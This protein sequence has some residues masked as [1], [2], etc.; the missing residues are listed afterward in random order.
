MLVCSNVSPDAIDDDALA[1]AQL[2]ALAERA[3]ERGIRI[4]YEALAWGRHVSDYDHA[5]RIVEAGRPPRARHLPGQLPHPLA[6]RRP[7]R[8]RATIPGEKIFF[9]QLADAPHLVMDVLQWSRHYRCFPGQGGFDLAGFLAHVLRRRLRRA[10]V[11]RGL[12]R[13]LPPGRPEPHGRRRDALAAACSRSA[14]SP[15]CRRAALARLRVRRARRRRRRRRA[16]TER[17]AAR[18]G[19]RATPASTAPSRCSCGEHGDDPRRCSTTAR[20]DDG[21]ARSP[22]SRVESADPSRSAARA[23]ALLAPVL[24]RG[25]GAGRGRPV[26][27]RRA[28][29]H[30]VF[31]CRTG[32]RRLARRLPRRSGDAGAARRCRSTGI[33]HVA[34]VAAVRLLRRGGAVLPLG[35]RPRAGDERRSSPRPTGSCA[36]APSRSADGSVRLALSV[37]ALAG[38]QRGRPSSSTSRSRCDDVAR[39][40]PGDARARR[41]AARRSPTT[42]TTTSRRDSTSTRTLLDALRELGVLYDRDARRRAPALL[43]APLGGRVFFEVLERRGGYD[44]YGAVNSPVR[45]A[46]QRRPVRRLS[47]R[48]RDADDAGR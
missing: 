19:L 3:A 37:P 42:T 22:R 21:A 41:A 28:R 12:Q 17:A 33:D 7:G 40:R 18:A 10:A 45:M 1:A 23:E 30:A 4:A 47:T 2:R 5:W 9:L 48:R 16:E 8:H 34:L 44:G 27:G 20:G 11:A 46:A 13:R 24:P 6:R 15:R 29:R 25:R 14:G 39:R 32:R 35:A 38:A 31:F 26:R 43:H 36:A